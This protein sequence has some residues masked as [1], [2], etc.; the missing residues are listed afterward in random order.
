MT[1][2]IIGIEQGRENV[3]RPQDKSAL[4]QAHKA[5]WRTFALWVTLLFA[6]LLAEGLLVWSVMEEHLLLSLAAILLVAHF[7]HGQLM[8]FH[9]AAHGVLCPKQ[10]INEAVGCFIGALHFNSL[11]LFRSAHHSHHAHLG[12]ERDE[13]LWPFVDPRVPRSVRC[14]VAVTEVCL[15][16]VFEPLKFW[17]TFLRNHTSNAALCRRVWLETS[18]MLAFWSVILLVTAYWNAWKWLVLLFVVPAVLAGSSHVMRTYIE[19]MGMM[20][21]SVEGLS[22]TV[23]PRGRMGRLLALSLLNV[24]YHGVHH[25][26]A[27]L[28]PDALPYFVDELTSHPPDEPEVFSSYWHAFCDMLPSLADPKIGPQWERAMSPERAHGVEPAEVHEQA[29][30]RPGAGAR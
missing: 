23:A 13:E 6:L 11:S 29:Y 18:T 19:H 14:L 22:R 12:T 25:V 24:T 30:A 7:A 28:S 3:M 8:A 2:L 4:I 9:E 16:I 10:F 5:R 17:R 21:T 1:A 15:A 27:R 26:Y 20:G